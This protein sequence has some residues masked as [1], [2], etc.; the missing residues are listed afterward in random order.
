MLVVVFAVA[1]C[2]GVKTFPNRVAPGE[3]V[4]VSAG[5]KHQFSRGNISVTITPEGQSAIVIPPGNVRAS[6]NVYPDPLSSIA[7]SH[8]T[9]SDVSAFSASY[10]LTVN[11]LTGNDADWWQNVIFVDVP[12]DAGI[13]AGLADITVSNPEGETASATVRIVDADPTYGGTADSFD[14]Q[15]LGPI[16]DVQFTSME[17]VDHYVVDFSGA[18]LPYAVQLDLSYTDMSGHVVNPSGLSKNV[19]WRDDTLG[20][21]YRVLLTPVNLQTFPEM[22]DLKFYVAVL[23]GSAATVDLSLVPG[24][25]RAF[26][27]N[28]DTVTGVSVNVALV[29]GAAGLN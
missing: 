27:A 1:G 11:F 13:P 21:T 28:G 5:W 18:T 4:A 19:S 26:D 10:A 20:G 15:F 25:L 9:G 22:K 6:I 12:A 7:I 3:T 17:R 14:A 2:S 24:S 16:N 23:S 8:R 29:R